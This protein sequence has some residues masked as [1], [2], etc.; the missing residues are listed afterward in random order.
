MVEHGRPSTSGPGY[1]SMNTMAKEGFVWRMGKDEATTLA[2]QADLKFGDKEIKAGHYS[3]WAKRVGK[4]WHLLFNKD[5]DVWGT[6]HVAGSDVAEIPM[7]ATTLDPPVELLTIEVKPDPSTPGGGIFR[8]AW[9]TE[10][11]TAK[12]TVVQPPAPAPSN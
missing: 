9:G 8:L 1:K 11:G 6:K 10:E 12:F 5:A 2:T 7:E 4:G 3:L